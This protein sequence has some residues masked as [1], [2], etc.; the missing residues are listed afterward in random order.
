MAIPSARGLRSLGVS[1]ALLGLISFVTLER[2][3]WIV[4]HFRRSAYRVRQYD[5]V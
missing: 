3:S 1:G 2:G 4:N 5:G